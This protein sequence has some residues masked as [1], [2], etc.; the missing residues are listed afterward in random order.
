MGTTQ[1]GQSSQILHWILQLL[2]EVHP[3]FLCNRLATHR[4]NQE[5]GIFQLGEGAG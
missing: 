5:R 3:P 4:P 2:S 1:V